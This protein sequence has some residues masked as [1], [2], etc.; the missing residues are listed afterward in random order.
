MCLYT[1]Q[2]FPLIAQKDIT[3]SKQLRKGCISPYFE[4]RYKLGKSYFA[5]FRK[6]PSILTPGAYVIHNGLHSFVSAFHPQIE[7]GC[8]TY[9][10]YI[11][12]G[13]E[14]YV[15]QEGDIVSNQLVVV[16]RL[17]LIDLLWYKIFPPKI[18]A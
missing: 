13:S 5:E 7:Y 18:E 2:T 10:A 1:K 11:P 9:K 12:K 3:V 16:R 6:A 17:T 8:K 14:Y 15:G 4:L